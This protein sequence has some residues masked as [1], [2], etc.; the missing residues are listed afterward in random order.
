MKSAQKK[1][2]ID[3]KKII[4]S[5]ISPYTTMPHGRT[6]STVKGT[7]DRKRREKRGFTD[8]TKKSFK[9]TE[10]NIPETSEFPDLKNEVAAVG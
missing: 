10:D 8:E 4:S 5:P 9:K 6:E 1:G 3:M 7:T 2:N